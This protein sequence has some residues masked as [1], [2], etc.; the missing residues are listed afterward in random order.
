M[1]L[2]LILRYVGIVLIFNALFMMISL[3]VSIVNGFDTGFT[4]LLMSTFLTFMMGIFPLIFTYGLK[5]VTLNKKESYVVVACSWMVSCIIGFFPYILWGGEFSFI[6]AMFESVSGYT[7]TGATILSDVESLPKSLLFWRSSTHLLG[8]A[9]V[10]IF[11]L[12]L[13]P[14]LNKSRSSLTNI[15]LSPF[16]KDNFKYK[17]KKAIRVLVTV[18]ILLVFAEMILLK[19]AGMSWFD[20]VNHAFSTIGT[21]GFSTKNTSI[22]YF[23]NIWIEI[24]IIVFMTIASLHFGVVHATFTGK[25]QNIFRSEVSIYYLLTILACVVIITLNLWTTNEFGFLDSLRYGSFQFVSIISTTGFATQDTAF[26]PSLSVAIIILYTFQ[27]GCAG[28]TAGGIKADRILILLKTFGAE[29]K[30]IRHQ[31]AIVNIRLGGEP[32]SYDLVHSTLIFAFLFVA[33]VLVGTLFATMMGVDILT[34]LTGS[35]A[36][37]ANVGPGFGDVSSM[38]NFASL[39]DSVKVVFSVAMLAGRLELYGF[40][41]ILFIDSWK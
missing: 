3:L 22:A 8:G 17:M 19:I 38:S 10:V 30:K 37:V 41:Q 26:W 40:L 2:Q 11:A 29:F 28:S 27:S 9:G 13:I 39:P 12:A 18:Y 34:A 7:T 23:D 25:K 20:A 15:E 14:T 32:V 1:K 24:I 31:D 36:C 33:T 4:P 5:E 21:G 16:V 6:N 35:L